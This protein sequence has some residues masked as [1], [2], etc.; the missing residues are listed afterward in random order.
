MIASGKTILMTL[1]FTN[2]PNNIWSANTIINSYANSP[3]LPTMEAY[4]VGIVQQWARHGIYKNQLFKMS[5]TLTPNADTIL[6]M[7][8]PGFPYT[9][10]ELADIANNDLENWFDTKV[11]DKYKYPFLS[12]IIIIDDYSNSQIVEIVLRGINALQ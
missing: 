2:L 8:F 9:L 11:A 12:N 3:V 6:E 5:W 10:L 1:E 7:L 4:N